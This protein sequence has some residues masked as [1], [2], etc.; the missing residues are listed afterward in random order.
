MKQR[1]T[2]L[3]IRATVNELK[4]RLIGKYIQNF[5]ST[6][7]RIIYI[8]FSNKDVL[9]AE[10]GV[11]MHLTEGHDMDISHFCKILRKRAR[12]EKV[13]DIY[14]CGFDRIVIFELSKQKIV[15]EF[16]S[17]GNVLIVQDNKIVEVFRMVKDLDVVK[18]SEYVFNNVEFDFGIEMFVANEISDFLPVEEPLVKEVL[19]GLSSKLGTDVMGMRKSMMNGVPIKKESRDAF[20][21]YMNEFKKRIEE[22]GGYGGVV[23]AKGK[24][25]SLF[26]FKVEGAREF[27]TF[28]DAA[29]FFFMD[30]KKFGKGDKVSKVDK[31]RARQEAYMEEMKKESEEYV[32]KAHA[33]ESNEGL[34]QRILDIFRVVRESKM[35][36]NDFDRFREKENKKQNEV[37]K[38]ILQCDFKSHRCLI[39]VDGK[40]VDVD[41]NESLFCNVNELFKKA[42]KLNEKIEK[43]RSNLE[44]VLKKIAPKT[45]TKRIARQTYWFEKFH[46][47]FSSEGAVV[48]GGKNSQQNEI[49]VKKYLC[50]DDLYFHS[51]AH[52]CSSVIVKKESEATIREA[53]AMTLCMS[54]CWT[55]GVVSQIWYVY[56][57]QVSKTPPSGEYLP[58]GSFAI[59]GKKNYV[60]WHRLEY[61]VGIVFR[62][63][64]DIEEQVSEMKVGDAEGGEERYKFMNDP[65]DL[66][67]MHAIPVCGPWCVISKY[68]YKLKLVPGGEKKGKLVQE[69]M[70]RFARDAGES[71]EEMFVKAISTEEYMN[72]LPVSIRIGK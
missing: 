41:F 39:S 21:E 6:S 45:E 1:Y 12:R 33:L 13:V 20:E 38:A 47:F 48:I 27:G 9:L 67:I 4:P 72:V 55:N 42:K 22:I 46:F 11:R 24:L 70:K 52:G 3:D 32:A 57:N 63:F 5:Y 43:T 66:E 2:F 15:F 60:E 53:A 25:L 17:G 28:N 23:M 36:W 40:E 50:D 59:K 56:G 71:K 31:V 54:S 64:E 61:G 16:F 69:I 18:G 51:D 49:L 7:Q 34:V 30:R 29:E 37:S 26:P 44:D 14:Q 35:K 10:P 19:G 8:K 58:K 62:A 68:K 65:G